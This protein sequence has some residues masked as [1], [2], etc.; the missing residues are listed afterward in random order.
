VWRLN[1]SN[2]HVDAP[3][4]H[5]DHRDDTA[6]LILAN[7]IP[8]TCQRGFAPDAAGNAGVGSVR[9]RIPKVVCA[10]DAVGRVWNAAGWPRK[11]WGSGIAGTTEW[12]SSPETGLDADLQTAGLDADLQSV[13]CARHDARLVRCHIQDLVRVG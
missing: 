5:I 3:G 11:E 6:N 8:D 4:K 2:K 10:T 1:S 13:G 9:R 7:L 12:G